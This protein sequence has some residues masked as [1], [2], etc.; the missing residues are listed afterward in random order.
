MHENFESGSLRHKPLV[1]ILEKRVR[2]DGV[3]YVELSTGINKFVFI[4]KNGE[5]Y[6]TSRTSGE[7]FSEEILEQVRSALVD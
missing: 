7:T 6:L 4:L 5:P 3:R 2:P 1:P